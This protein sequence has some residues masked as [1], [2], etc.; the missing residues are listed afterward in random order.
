MTGRTNFLSDQCD[1]NRLIAIALPQEDPDDRGRLI[2]VR[3][4]PDPSSQKS[5][6]LRSA[7]TVDPRCHD[8]V[9]DRSCC[10][11]TRRYRRR[12][13]QLLTPLGLDTQVPDASTGSFEG[14]SEF[15][16]NRLE[17]VTTP[18][19]RKSPISSKLTEGDA[20]DRRSYFETFLVPPGY[21]PAARTAPNPHDRTD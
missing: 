1:D 11:A 13:L 16:G 21:R 4:R 15:C 6:R 9:G 5:S 12:D 20:I 2:L 8:Q 17:P 19:N 14:N 7:C 18:Q 10:R 3:F